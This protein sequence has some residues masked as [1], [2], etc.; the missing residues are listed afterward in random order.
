M[1]D[2][3]NPND[4]KITVYYGKNKDYDHFFFLDDEKI[5]RLE[6]ILDYKF[7]YDSEFSTNRDNDFSLSEEAQIQYIC[8]N[9]ERAYFTYREL[10]QYDG[11]TDYK[12]Y[13]K[14]LGDKKYTV[15][16][17]AVLCKAMIKG[18]DYSDEIDN[19]RLI[20]DVRKTSDFLYNYSFYIFPCKTFN[21][22]FWEEIINLA[23]Y[24]N[25]CG[26]I[27]DIF[28]KE[29]DNCSDW[30]AMQ[31]KNIKVG[32]SF[33]DAYGFNHGCRIN[34]INNIENNTNIIDYIS[35]MIKN[36]SRI[37]VFIIK[38]FTLLKQ[39]NE[40]ELD[41]KVIFWDNSNSDDFGNYIGF[42]E[43]SLKEEKKYYEIS[44]EEYYK[45]SDYV[46][47]EDTSIVSDKTLLIDRN[48]NP[49]E[50]DRKPFSWYFKT[51]EK[52]KDLLDKI[53]NAITL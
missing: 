46:I 18:F 36:D 39:F 51:S 29:N 47:T 38:D 19:K 45:Y 49:I 52:Y 13:I 14:I 21:S 23:F 12:E 33:I 25:K 2:I 5:K 4:D 22:S 44:D 26:G 24:I 9:L 3:L 15:D 32:N 50:C 20:D 28:I 10:Y 1:A 53:I 7:H 37:P 35:E 27:V 41:K 17:F 16:K 8:E 11:F 40:I 30:W 31:N 6:N 42:K 48:I 34:S 43:R